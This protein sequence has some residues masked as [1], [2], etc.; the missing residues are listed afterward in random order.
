MNTSDQQKRITEILILELG[1]KTNKY[2]IR[3]QHIP[4]DLN[5]NFGQLCQK[6]SKIFQTM[7]PEAPSPNNNGHNVDNDDIYTELLPISKL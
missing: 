2:R 6:Y 3:K 4:I 7:T 1:F 5:T